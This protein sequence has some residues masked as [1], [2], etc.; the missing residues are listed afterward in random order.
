MLITAL[1]NFCENVR[2]YLA[3]RNIFKSVNSLSSRYSNVLEPGCTSSCVQLVYISYQLC[4]QYPQVGG[5]KF[6]IV[7]VFTPQK[8][9]KMMIRFF[10][11]NTIVKCLPV[12]H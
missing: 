7:G 2:E 8:L 5:L 11:G 6:T 1:Q 12:Y 9:A 4:V 10:S 3:C